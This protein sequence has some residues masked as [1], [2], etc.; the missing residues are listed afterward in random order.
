[1]STKDSDSVGIDEKDAVLVEQRSSPETI[2]VQDDSELLDPE[3]RPSAERK[4]VRT[5][6]MR[7]MPTIIVIFILNYIDVRSSFFLI[8][9]I[10]N[11]I[12]KACCCNSCKTT[13]LDAGS[14]SHR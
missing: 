7:L 12:R 6:D 4:L 2:Q 3:V 9:H 8:E 11:R 13:R 1:M 5:L 10:L 14:P